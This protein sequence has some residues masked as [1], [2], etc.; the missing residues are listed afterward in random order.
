M[1]NDINIITHALWNSDI[2]NQKGWSLQAKILGQQVLC[3]QNW[4]KPWTHA[5][6][7]EAY[8]TYKGGEIS[9]TSVIYFLLLI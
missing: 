1:D 6:G 9:A 5:K 2:P 3:M 8:G 7:Y 4:L